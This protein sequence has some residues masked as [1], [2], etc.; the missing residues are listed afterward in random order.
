VT[1]LGRAEQTAIRLWGEDEGRRV[2][3]FLRRLAR[4]TPARYPTLRVT[5]DRAGATAGSMVLDAVTELAVLHAESGGAASALAVKA[6]AVV[7]SD[8]R[9]LHGGAV[10]GTPREVPR[11]PDWWGFDT[12]EGP[13][14]GD[15]GPAVDLSGVDPR[16]VQVMLLRGEGVPFWQAGEMAGY[17]VK[18]PTGLR[19]GRYS[20]GARKAWKS[21]VRR[22][23]EGNPHLVER[24]GLVACP[25]RHDGKRWCSRCSTTGYIEKEVE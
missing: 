5:L 3:R 24:F 23:L 9:R 18:D 15:G 6:W 17:V 7:V 10:G 1:D 13:G 11:M 19:G 4:V 21:G 8:T 16:H 25:E 22:L 12:A 20:P 14:A 2:I